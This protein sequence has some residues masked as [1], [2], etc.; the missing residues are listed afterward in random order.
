MKIRIIIKNK[1]YYPQYFF[2]SYYNESWKNFLIGVSP[3]AFQI[4]EDADDFL[5]LLGSS[6]KPKKKSKSPIKVI[7]ENEIFNE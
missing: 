4:E 7:F 5:R 2:R 1:L 3:I 6:F